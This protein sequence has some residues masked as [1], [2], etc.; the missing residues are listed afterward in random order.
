[1]AKTQVE[2]LGGKITV[3]SELN[4]GAEFTVQLPV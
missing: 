1:M 3:Q 2:T 4:K